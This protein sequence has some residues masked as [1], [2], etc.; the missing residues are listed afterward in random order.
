VSTTSAILGEVAQLLR[1]RIGMSA[2]TVGPSVLTHAVNQ[3]MSAR[4]TDNAEVYR[5]LL[6]SSDE[7]VQ[8]LI[9]AVTVPETWFFRD[10]E[11]FAAM[12]R[13][14]RAHRP[15]GRPIRVLSVPCSSGE[16]AYSIAMAIFDAG[17]AAPD[18]TVDGIDV[19]SRKIPE[20]ERAV[21]GKNSFRGA[22]LAY[23]DRH[24]EPVAG[25]YRPKPA[26]RA[27]A[28]FKVGNIFDPAL[29][30]PATY[31]IAFCRNLLIY[32]DREL[33]QRALARLHE[34]L[35]PEGLLL[36]GPA[37]SSLPTSNGFITT[38][39][40]MAF[41]F[42]KRG[43]EAAAVTPVRVATP[44]VRL[45]PARRAPEPRP[46]PRAPALIPAVVEPPEDVER[47]SF[48]V[49]ERSANAGHLDETRR[50]AQR[51][52]DRFGP[53]AEVL[54]LLGLAHDAQRQPHAAIEHYRKALYL[55]PDHAEALTHLA[56]LLER[57]GDLAAAR[58]ILERLGRVERRSGAR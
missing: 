11:A 3:R 2:E 51:H 30:G 40:P 58:V 4:D 36:V 37:E 35:T 32:F 34:L 54:Y 16:E 44:R 17:F 27:Q 20:A 18:F 12:A 19:S 33:Q 45:A 57:Q 49:I 5:R 31:D 7:E 38:R 10:P 24:F 14:A 55:A 53:S 23:R 15:V 13:H 42:T 28:R 6:F 22:N 26:I 25:G 9:N 43:A 48:E 8:E 56:L 52:M 50:E 46:A 41:A 1:D 21:Y 39:M 47:L 29:A